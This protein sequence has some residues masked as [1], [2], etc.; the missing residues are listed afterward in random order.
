MLD[1][2]GD[3]LDLFAFDLLTQVFDSLSEFRQRDLMICLPGLC[4]NS[5]QRVVGQHEMGQTDQMQ[6]S[7]DSLPLLHAL[8]AQTQFAAQF[9]EHHFDQPAFFVDGNYVAWCA[10]MFVRCHRQNLLPRVS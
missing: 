5:A 7:S 1:A 3:G 2:S 10:T 8:F 6:V 9:L 4:T